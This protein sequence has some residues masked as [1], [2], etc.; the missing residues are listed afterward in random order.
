MVSEPV[1]GETVSEVGFFLNPVYPPEPAGP[2]RL[3]FR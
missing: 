2:Q 1:A 3:N